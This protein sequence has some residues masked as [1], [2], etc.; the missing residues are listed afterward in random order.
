MLFN[1]WPA[2]F[3]IY[4]MIRIA[5]C[6]AVKSMAYAIGAR[7]HHLAQRGDLTNATGVDLTAPLR[8]LTMRSMI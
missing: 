1:Q 7:I 5:S 2:H 3:T 6:E 4:E 8:N